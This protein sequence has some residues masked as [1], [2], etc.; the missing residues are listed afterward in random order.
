MT[1]MTRRTVLRTAALATTT[2]ARPFVRGA[3]AAGKL[4]VGFWDHWVPGANEPLEALCREWAEKEKVE[5]KVDFITFNL[6][7][8]AFSVPTFVE[9]L[10]PALQH[11]AEE[12]HFSSG[13]QRQGEHCAGPLR[14]KARER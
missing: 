9:L 11:A 5:L 1:R 10:D 8:T 2:L 4:S 6:S 3:R 13:S 12:V 14:G 7:G